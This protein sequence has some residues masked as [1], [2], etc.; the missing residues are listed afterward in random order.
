MENKNIEYL[1]EQ[2]K[3]LGFPS[4]LVEDL[5]QHVGMDNES[6][7]LYY[8]DKMNEDYL[9]YELL[10]RRHNNSYEFNQYELSLKHIII[11]P[12]TVEGIDA[13]EL[14][15]KLS[16]VDGLYDKFLQEDIQ[17]TKQE[18]DDNINLI[19]TT[20]S[21]LHQLAETDKGKEVAKILMYKYFPE[22]EYEKFFSDYYQMQKLYEHKLAFPAQGDEAFAISV[23][24]D[25][26][27][28]KELEFFEQA[29]TILNN[30]VF[31]DETLAYISTSY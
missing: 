12:I 1:S 2:M 23:A 6:F 9:M 21:T 20:N 5:S 3:Q 22:S 15:R 25:T 16:K 27:K 31:S 17:M 8:S 24:Y 19:T 13:I 28:R 7:S 26:L 18:Y 4:R 29:S 14:D 10:F 11:P 30:H